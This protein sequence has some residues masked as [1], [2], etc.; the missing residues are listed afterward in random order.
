[1]IRC[2]A[3]LLDPHDHAGERPYVS[4]FVFTKISDQLEAERAA[5]RHTL[6]YLPMEHHCVGLKQRYFG[7]CT[8][9]AKN[10]L[11]RTSVRKR[12]QPPNHAMQLTAGRSGTN[13]CDNF[14]IQPAAMLALSQR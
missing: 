13:F 10:T 2:A 8:P 1:M 4:S 12:P 14:H 11:V 5:T 7:L 9:E 6:I 3:V